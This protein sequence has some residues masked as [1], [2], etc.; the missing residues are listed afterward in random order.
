[1][2]ELAPID[3][4]VV[5]DL[6]AAYLTALVQR[7]VK[8]DDQELSLTRLDPDYAKWDYHVGLDGKPISGRGKR[9]ASKIWTP[10]RDVSSVELRQCFQEDG[11]FYGHT[12][13][14]TAWRRICGLVGYHAS[15]PKDNGC[16]RNPNGYLYVPCSRFD[17]GHRCLG[18][19]RLDREWNAHWSFVGFRELA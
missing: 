1:M 15:I 16:W 12:A 8:L 3:I 19:Y 4:V 17:G 18:Q 7:G 13:A 11:G 14:F 6:A 5:P 2:I 10:R 9:F